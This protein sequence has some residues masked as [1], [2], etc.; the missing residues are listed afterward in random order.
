MQFSCG[1]S[2]HDPGKHRVQELAAT[3]EMLWAGHF[4]HGPWFRPTATANVVPGTVVVAPA[5]VVGCGV[6][7]TI[8]VD[9]AV[10]PSIKPLSPVEAVPAIHGTHTVLNAF[11]HDP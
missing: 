5:T 10:T 1:W 2:G 8:A 3:L 7:V 6:V 11:G 4:A 9:V